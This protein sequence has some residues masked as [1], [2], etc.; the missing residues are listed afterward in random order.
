MK[1]DNKEKRKPSTEDMNRMM[2]AWWRSSDKD[3]NKGG[4]SGELQVAQLNALL[5][6]NEYGVM[7][8]VM[9]KNIKEDVV[10]KTTQIDHLLVHYKTGTIFVIETKKIQGSIHGEAQG[11]DW[12]VECHNGSISKFKNPL[13][14]NYG[15]VQCVYDILTKSAGLDINPDQMR[16][17]VIYLPDDMN[18]Q[19]N[20]KN[21]VSTSNRWSHL[22]D[23]GSVF[24]SHPQDYLMLIP[25]EV[26]AYRKKLTKYDPERLQEQSNVSQQY[27]E[28]LQAAN[29][30]SK[31]A[32]NEHVKHLVNHYGVSSGHQRV[33][34]EELPLE[35]KQQPVSSRFRNNRG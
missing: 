2:K 12:F 6:S 10:S 28:I 32:Q 25:N 35:V 22:F 11:D 34:P 9:F 4:R 14:Q 20:I 31:K 19:H 24:V 17:I 3:P 26:A 27:F 15:H 13:K 1:Y 8:N 16:S 5:D 33:D 7:N 30:M 29:I 18:S 23:T 21:N